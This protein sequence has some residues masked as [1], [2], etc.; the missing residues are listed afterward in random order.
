VLSG[1]SIGQ[2]LVIQ[3][4]D[5]AGST[6]DISFCL[7]EFSLPPAPNCATEPITP[8]D[9]S[10]DIAV[11]T[12]VTVSW[13]APSTG[14]VPTGYEVFIGLESDGSDLSSI[15]TTTQ[16]SAD[17]TFNFYNTTYYW[18][19]TPLNGE[20]SADG[21][22]IWSFTTEAFTGSTPSPLDTVVID[23]CGVMQTSSNAYDASV[24]G[25]QWIQLDYAGGCESLVIDTNS[26]TGVTDTELGLYT[27]DGSAIALSDDDGDGLLSLIDIS[28]LEAGTYYIATGNWDM[29]FAP[30][31]DV[32][33][34]NT[35]ATGTI[36]VSIMANTALSV[37]CEAYQNFNYYPNP[38]QDRVFF[39]SVEPID[40]L[41]V[42][43]MLGQRVM[44]VAPHSFS[45]E[46][47]IAQL[48]KGAYFIRVSQEGSTNTI[49]ILKQ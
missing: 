26:T 23:E 12:P 22:S 46:L 7:E 17:I 18:R 37:N 8:A 28:G 21:C 45:P 11:G 47:N 5:F 36:V 14:P 2:E 1:W 6:S 48:K 34:S 25:V 19:I 32:T 29:T 13:T 27:S 24:E 35:T 20:N 40:Q 41:T 38:A 31:F 16:T 49:R 9:G 43:N 33:T 10:V 4:F 42:Y 44:D 15:G 39:E 30:G 3:V